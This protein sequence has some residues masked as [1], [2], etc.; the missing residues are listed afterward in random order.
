MIIMRSI[1]FTGTPISMNIVFLDLYGVVPSYHTSMLK[2]AHV[3]S[4]NMVFPIFSV[5]LLYTQEVLKGF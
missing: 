5:L 2:N 1:D 3:G 4:N